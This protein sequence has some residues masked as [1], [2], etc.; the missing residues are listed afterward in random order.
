MLTWTVSTKLAAKKGVTTTKP[1]LNKKKSLILLNAK[2]KEKYHPK[3][4]FLR[5]AIDQEY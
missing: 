3:I 4:R 5:F 2:F 1:R